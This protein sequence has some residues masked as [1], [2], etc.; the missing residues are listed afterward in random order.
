MKYEEVLAAAKKLP[1][2]DLVS[3]R[4]DIAGHLKETEK[5]ALAK[6]KAEAMEALKKAGFDNVEINLVDPAAGRGTGRTANKTSEP[7][8]RNPETGEEWVGRGKQPHW[9]KAHIENGGD[10]EDFRIRA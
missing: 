3:L 9:I 10:K 2:P 5:E 4:D 1:R 6:A 7:Q 8:F